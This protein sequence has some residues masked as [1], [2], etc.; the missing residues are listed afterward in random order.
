MQRSLGLVSLEYLVTTRG[1]P[2]MGGRQYLRGGGKRKW[3]EHDSMRRWLVEVRTQQ[4]SKK[5]YKAS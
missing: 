1:E 3:L 4:Q 2:T 5:K